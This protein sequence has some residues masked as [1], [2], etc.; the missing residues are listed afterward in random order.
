VYLIINTLKKDRYI[1]K[2]DISIIPDSINKSFA[3]KKKE[4]IMFIF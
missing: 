4:K 1:E 3:K 2:R